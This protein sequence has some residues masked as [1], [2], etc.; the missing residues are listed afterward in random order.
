MCVGGEI[1]LSYVKQYASI[2]SM[3]TQ[4]MK[5]VKFSDL[6]PG[7]TARARPSDMSP[8][9]GPAVMVGGLGPGKLV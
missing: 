6:D 1:V 4:R 2:R 7:E 9:T 3:V 5:A 8:P